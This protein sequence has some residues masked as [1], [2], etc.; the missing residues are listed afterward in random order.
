MAV[1][2]AVRAEQPLGVRRVS[3]VAHAKSWQ[4]TG[5]V[6]FALFMDY[7]IYGLVV[8][9]T[10]YSPAGISGEE[11]FGLLYGGYGQNAAISHPRKH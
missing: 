11:E 7:F 4:V 8:P 3:P 2:E 10:L 5:V 6:A 1:G 9:L